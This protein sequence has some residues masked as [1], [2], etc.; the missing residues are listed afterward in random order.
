VSKRASQ[1]VMR[2]MRNCHRDMR[3]E[4][5]TRPCTMKATI[6]KVL[7]VALALLAA[8]VGGC[9]SSGQNPMGPATNADGTGKVSF[10]LQTG[11]AALST[12][13]W[14]IHH[15]TL[16]SADLTGS[17]DVSHSQAVQFIVSGLP[18]GSGYTITLAATTDGTPGFGCAGTTA[19]D[20]V[21]N[22][23]REVALAIVCAS[24][25]A[26]AGDNGSVVIIATTT[27]APPAGQVLVAAQPKALAAGPG[28]HTCA[29]LSDTTV[30][31]WGYNIAGQLGDGTTTDSA[32]PVSVS[33][34]T[35]ATAVTTG[36]DH[37]CARLASGSAVCWGAQAAIGNGAALGGLDDCSGLPCSMK[38]VPVMGLSDV[39]AIAAGAL[40]T[41]AVTGGA[42]QCWGDNAS[43]ELGDGTQVTPQL[44]PVSVKGLAGA[45]TA[46]SVGDSHSCALMA[47][48]S[49]QCWG[50]DYSGQLGNGAAGPDNCGGYPCSV[51]P[52]TVVG[53]HNVSSIAAGG[54]R[55]CAL[56]ADAT[57]RCWGFNDAGGELGNGTPTSSSSP[58]TVS[59]LSSVTAL[60]A[61]VYHTCALVAGGAVQCWGNN[62]I[63]AGTDYFGAFCNGAM[64]TATT[65]VGV[66]DFTGATALSA[67]ASYTCALLPGAKVECCGRNA[68]GQLGNGATLTYSAT[69]VG[70]GL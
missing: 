25:N 64:Q 7:F 23:T 35:G 40:H 43:G 50:L 1:I 33:N 53:L 30:K 4:R 47:D 45:V 9:S 70:V 57:V 68:L 6:G 16:L 69:P 58:V 39:T 46:I 18:A 3:T 61:G 17:V 59:N 10:Q 19:F 13:N 36:N 12:V 32:T 37:T 38:P 41:C 20:V 2:S 48:G 67:G 54:S 15:P 51:K 8:S 34:L 52:L 11:A 65:P 55:T 66:P 60:A 28:S 31:C 62:S 5:P 21:A 49:V 44:A 42:V 22:T 14:V 56:L 29:L 63:G 24:G 27:I 26:D